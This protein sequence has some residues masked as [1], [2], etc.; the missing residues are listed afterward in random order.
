MHT[1]YG[2][3]PYTNVKICLAAFTA[4]ALKWHLHHHFPRRHV[5]YFLQVQGLQD[6]EMNQMPEVDDYKHITKEEAI[7]KKGVKINRV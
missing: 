3:Y 1:T 7:D 5:V 6:L 4:K 2:N